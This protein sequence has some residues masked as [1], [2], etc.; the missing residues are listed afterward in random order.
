MTVVSTKEFNANQEKYFDMALDDHVI[1][2]RGNNMFIVQSFVS[3]NEP[4]IIFTPDED[5]FRSISMDEFLVGAK[6]DLCEIFS[7]GKR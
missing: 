1:I 3:N 6:E 2:K 7:K 5:F 4:D